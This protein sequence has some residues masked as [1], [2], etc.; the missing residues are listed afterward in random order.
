LI[1]SI[2]CIFIFAIGITGILTFLNSQYVVTDL[3]SQMQSE[4][5]DRIIQHLDVYLE[6]PHLVNNLC[7]DSIRLGE[8]SISDNDSIQRH[9]Q[10]LSYRFDSVQAICYANELEGNYTIISSIG[11]PGIANGT[12]RFLG[13]SR[14]STNFSFEEYRIDRYGKIIEK[15]YSKAGYDPRSRPWYN[16]AVQAKGSV[17]TPVYMWLEGIVSIDAVVP[18]YSEKGKLQGVLD[19]S[20]TLSGIGDFLQKIQISKNGQAF[21]IDRSGHI[22]ASSAIRE[23]YTWVNG[24]LRHQSALNCNNSI[25]QKTTRKINLGDN[26]LE[27]ITTRQQYN[28]DLEGKRY[29]VQVT[30]F[31]D[32]YG[33]DWLIVVVVPESDFME[34][35]NENNRT[36][37][38]LIVSSIIGTIIVCVLLARWITEP[39]LS[40]NQSAK[41]L[42]GGDWNSWTELDRHDELGELS[43]SFKK[44]ADQLRSSFISLKSSEEQ[45]LSLFQSS[46]DAIL[47]FDKLTLINMNRAGEEMFGVL[48]A[49]AIGK[50]IRELFGQVGTDIGEMIQSS[51]IEQDK[52]Y[53]D[54]TI[55]RIVDGVEQFINIRA[56]TVVENGK[57]FSLI[58]IRDITEQRRAIMI[59]AEQEA[60]RRSYNH[61]QTILQLLP[62]PSFV[63]DHKGEVLFWNRAMEKMTG[64]KAEEIIGKGNESYSLAVYG[65]VRSLLI[66]V[67]LHPE[68]HDE[69]VF[70][71]IEHSGGILKTSIWLE[72]S[73]EMK[74]LSIIAASL[75]DENR[76][77]IGAI[78]SIRDITSHKISEEALLIA[79]KKLNLLSSIT[80]HDIINKIMISK[81]FLYLLE[82]SGENSE[83]KSSI[84]AIKRSMAEI[85]HFIE[86]TKTYQELGLKIPVW[87][88]VGET[89]S[90][91][92]RDI[93]SGD[94]TIQ[95]EVLGIS[96]LVDP[97]FEKV[98]YNLIENAL[99]HGERL[100]RID[101]T[102]HETN[103]GIVISIQ[104]DGQGVPQDMKEIIFE[105]GY[106]K[107]TGYG[108]FLARE[109]LS[110]S[111]IS[112]TEKGEFGS[113]CRFDIDVPRGKYRL[114][115]E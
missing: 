115:K 44:M 31:Q 103:N 88:D 86:F 39:I 96:I 73:G 78:E 54:R 107:N 45:Y 74:Y 32:K 50:D 51:F 27:K 55:I 25:I 35:T 68:L 109:I 6:T 105:R 47:L 23:P 93:E 46:T 52:G 99:R 24:E 22:V 91:A 66:D 12:E 11:E 8:I 70:P 17:W 28:F 69:E 75:Y 71:D 42:A 5:S 92:A 19:T 34:K 1:V 101:I 112:I 48:T 49:Q 36:T 20:L 76:C 16:A 3:A 113:Y 33:I 37:A 94:V 110:L 100:T 43:R 60:L 90:R 95:V 40:M 59:L 72:I 89:F 84:E 15:T 21:I 9:F 18:V 30:P 7:M 87:K 104:D 83:Q 26:S 29:F 62:D 41:A 102:A 106:G 61:I 53:Q 85:E 2:V 111:N 97:L 57:Q 56:T 10:E 65:S 98:C 63:I 38:I 4:I 114:E 13:I 81:G 82:E 79:N 80:R 64:V 58:H 77:L 67:A 14:E 108:L